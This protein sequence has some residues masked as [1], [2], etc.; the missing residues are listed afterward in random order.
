MDQDNAFW[1]DGEWVSWDDINRQVQHQEWRAKYPKGDLALVP[2]FE[3]LLS[4][5]EEYHSITG[6][7]L[8]IYGELGELYAAI[9]HG[10]KLHKA[11]AQGSDGRLGDDF[12]EVKTITP[13]NSKNATSVKLSGNFNKLFVVRINEDFELQGRMINRSDLPK[14]KSGV[15]HLTWDG[16]KDLADE[17]PRLF[18][19]KTP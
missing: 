19:R 2:I 12:V 3:D 15:L 9:T 4:T 17:Q 5:A 1:D 14:T 16:I 10:I 13:F 18:A 11:R 6:R 7:H 8:Q